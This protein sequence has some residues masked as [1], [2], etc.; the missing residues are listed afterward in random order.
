MPPRNPA[1][2]ILHTWTGSCRGCAPSPSPGSSACPDAARSPITARDI[3]HWR[4]RRLGRACR[5]N[6]QAPAKAARGSCPLLCG[7]LGVGAGLGFKLPDLITQQLLLL[8]TA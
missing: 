5:S 8:T 4:D 6:P 7:I 1:A 3:A 2:G